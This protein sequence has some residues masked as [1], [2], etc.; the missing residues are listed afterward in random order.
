[1]IADDVL[2]EREFDYALWLIVYGNANDVRFVKPKT[3]RIRNSEIQGE[4]H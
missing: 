3:K 1:M 4:E 2:Y